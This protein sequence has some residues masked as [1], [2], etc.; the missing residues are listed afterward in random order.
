MRSQDFQIS[1]AIIP[2]LLRKALARIVGYLQE[3]SQSHPTE[4][5]ASSEGCTEDSVPQHAEY[6]THLNTS[7]QPAF[8]NSKLRANLQPPG[9]DPPPQTHVA[10]ALVTVRRNTSGLLRSETG[11][12]KH[13]EPGYGEMSS[14]TSSQVYSKSKWGP[15]C[16]QKPLL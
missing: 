5:G 1:K 4:A 15:S 6:R 8:H 9:K 16:H 12:K 13:I 3:T 14:A 2:T 11:I 7:I 10:V